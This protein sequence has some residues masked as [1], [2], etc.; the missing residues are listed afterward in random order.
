MRRRLVLLCPLVALVALALPV[1]A[2]AHDAPENSQS[3]YVMVDWM[4]E[5]FLIFALAAL[6]GFIWAWKAGMFHD[7]EKQ[8][9]IPLGIDEP[10]YYTPEWA[11]DEE[12]WVDAER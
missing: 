2:L 11:L 4:I 10:D 9:R 7:L 8:A 12:E 5:T 1:A 6:V 3:R